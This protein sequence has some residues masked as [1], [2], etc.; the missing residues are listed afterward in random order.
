MVYLTKNGYSNKKNKAVHR[1]KTCY[2]K[3]V[4][5]HDKRTEKEIRTLIMQY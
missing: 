1:E 3:K 2:K 5:K 4:L